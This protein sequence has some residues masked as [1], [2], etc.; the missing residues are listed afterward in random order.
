MKEKIIKL[1]ILNKETAE[2]LALTNKGNLYIRIIKIY[3]GKGSYWVKLA[4]PDFDK[5]MKEEIE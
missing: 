2:L 5:T 3:K 1:Y 4:N